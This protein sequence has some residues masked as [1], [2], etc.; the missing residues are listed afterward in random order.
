M[1]PPAAY[2]SIDMAGIGEKPVIRSGPCSLD[3]VHRGGGD[4]LEHRVPA[5]AP[6]PALAPGALVAR[7]LGRVAHQRAPGVDRVL[8]RGLRLAPQVEQR[9]PDVGVLHP[10]GAVE[11][12]GVRD[13]ALA[14]ARLVGRDRLVDDRIVERLHLPGDDPVLGVDVPR[15]AAGAVDTVGAAHDVVVLPAVAVELLPAPGLRVDQVLDEGVV[16]ALG[17]AVLHDY[18]WE[19][20]GSCDRLRVTSGRRT[21]RNRLRQTRSN[22]ISSS[23]APPMPA[24]RNSSVRVGVSRT[25]VWA[26]SCM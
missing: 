5:R 22:T 12:P 17:V 4:D 1:R 23:T 9:A 2:E 26:V 10:Q 6:Q 25:P 20:T 3:G 24:R 8:L 16:D 18:D 13:P 7:A 21:A 19:P 15:A 11:V 14:A